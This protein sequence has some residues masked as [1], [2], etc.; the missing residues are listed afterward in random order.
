MIRFLGLGLLVAGGVMIYWGYQSS[1]SFGSQ[2]NKS[3]TGSPTDKT[4][5]LMIGGIVC[6]A[7]GLGAFLR[8]K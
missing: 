1:E 3:F 4:I 6:A 7:A 2:M 8:G 5:R